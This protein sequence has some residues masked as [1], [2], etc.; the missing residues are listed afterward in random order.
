MN[1]APRA[2]HHKAQL[3]AVVTLFLISYSVQST[4]K[5]KVDFLYFLLT[6]RCLDTAENS[7]D[8]ADARELDSAVVDE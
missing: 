1:I 8:T 6:R 4:D 3:E 2:N 7:L 5:S